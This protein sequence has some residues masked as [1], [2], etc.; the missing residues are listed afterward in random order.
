MDW[1]AV[2]VEYITGNKSLRQL[3]KDHDVS[4]PT[5]SQRAAREGWY[6]DKKQ[7][8]SEVVA[9]SVEKINDERI[10]NVEKLLEATQKALDKVVEMIDNCD[11]D[12]PRDLKQLTSA[13]KDIR[14][15]LITDADKSETVKVIIGAC[16]DYAE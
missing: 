14:D 2:K 7:N 4:Y 3:A 12:E 11:L 5:L 13:L 15:I 1:D 9:K 10:G 6:A 8:R 16:E